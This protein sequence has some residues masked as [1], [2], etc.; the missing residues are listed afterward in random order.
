MVECFLF[1][2][3]INVCP[4]SC[5]AI[6]EI[7]LIFIHACLGYKGKLKL[8]L[9]MKV[10]NALE[11]LLWFM[12]ITV[13]QFVIPN[14]I[15]LNIRGCR[16]QSVHTDCPSANNVRTRWMSK[17][18]KYEKCKHQH[19]RSRWSVFYIIAQSRRFSYGI[20]PQLPW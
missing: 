12:M 3:Q 10:L 16:V 5:N 4:T 15:H 19:Q 9:P 2:Y 1:Y 8:S 17:Y 13:S 20:F 6:S 7:I 18:E 14:W 11:M